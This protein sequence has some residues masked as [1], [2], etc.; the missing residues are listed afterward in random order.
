MTFP[1]DIGLIYTGE[2]F[3]AKEGK[4]CPDLIPGG[5]PVEMAEPKLSPSTPPERKPTRLVHVQIATPP[6]RHQVSDY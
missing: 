3:L 2:F 6:S 1:L 4:Q 5:A